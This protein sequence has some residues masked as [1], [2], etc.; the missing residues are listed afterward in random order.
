MLD[1]NELQD[2]DKN[3]VDESWVSLKQN[4]DEVLPVTKPTGSVVNRTMALLLLIS[5]ICLTYLGY[6][7][8][9]ITP[10]TTITKEIIKYEKV[11]VPTSSPV[12][13]TIPQKTSR[14]SQTPENHNAKS[15]TNKSATESQSTSYS[16]S[17]N[18]LSSGFS[19]LNAMSST[20]TPKTREIQ[21][22][23]LMPI[24]IFDTNENITLNMPFTP[25]H[26]KSRQK[27]FNFFFA[28]T[29]FIS[30]L[31]YSGHGISMGLL[32][33]LSNKFSV[34]TGIGLNYIS[35]DY[36][37][38]PFFGNPSYSDFKSNATAD[39]NKA[40][41]YYEGLRGF[42]QI[43]IPFGIN[44][45]ISNKLSFNTAVKLRYT[46]SETIDQ[47]LRSRAEE[48]LSKNETVANSFFN[49][50]NVGISTGITYDISN[51]MSLRIDSEFGLNSLIN[52]KNIT[53]PTSH[54]Y[55]LNLINFTSY[56]K[57]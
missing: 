55:D 48:K 15:L 27:K 49:N 25:V 35:K 41:T 16:N 19:L 21:L 51:R 33:P 46:Y 39:L 17:L 28:A 40:N 7:Y 11:Y 30:N 22:L 31:D 53:D 29:G 38:L 54:K 42:K 2:W 50:S 32:L 47:V 23:D 4:L 13:E 18:P 26:D 8:Q 3:F 52:N 1:K 9:N 24:A 56:F 37:I 14:L 43:I 6:L 57:F 45:H 20:Y 34:E 5:I 10:S 12:A 44:Y 36:L